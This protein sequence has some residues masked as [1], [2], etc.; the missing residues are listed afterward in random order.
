LDTNLFCVFIIAPALID[1]QNPLL[2]IKVALND[3]AQMKREE[4]E[5]EV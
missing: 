3:Q 2:L 4:K 5:E 1:S